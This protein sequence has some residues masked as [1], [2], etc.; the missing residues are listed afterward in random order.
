MPLLLPVMHVQSS[1]MLPNIVSQTSHL[2]F[3][4]STGAVLTCQVHDLADHHVT[5]L[6]FD[7]LTSLSHPLA[8]DE[9]VFVTDQRLS[10]SAR[11]LSTDGVES[12]WSLT[13][14]RIALVDEGTYLCQIA[15]RHRTVNV[16][17]HVHVHLNMSLNARM[18]YVEPGKSVTIRCLLSI[19]DHRDRNVSVSVQ[20]LFISSTQNRSRPTDIDITHRQINDIWMSSLRIDR[21]S[22]HHTGMWTCVY[23]RQRR[24]ARVLVDHGMYSA[25]WQVLQQRLAYDLFRCGA[26]A[27]HWFA[28]IES[29]ESNG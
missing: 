14:D 21:A 23:K 10:V 11:R 9:D 17:F 26:T 28:S 20:W 5:W 12:T 15:H 2:T 13:I 7:P 29:I 3:N 4:Y 6:R 25:G 16:A 24:T 8:V 18:I 1:T 27:T 22:K 19:N